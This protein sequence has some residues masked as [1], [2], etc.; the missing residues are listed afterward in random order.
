MLNP[1][2]GAGRLVCARVEDA[3]EARGFAVHRLE[4]GEDLAE[5]AARLAVEA[6]ALAVAGGDGSLAAGAAVAI[7]HGLP[8]LPVPTGSL[9]HFARDAGL[10]RSD[11]VG[12]LAAIDGEAHRVDVGLA[13]GRV[14][15]NTLSFGVYAE[16][17]RDADYRHHKLRVGHRVVV[18]DDVVRSFRVS[19]T[20]H[21]R[22]V[23]T[24]A[25]LVV[26]TNNAHV[27]RIAERERLDAGVLQVSA[28]L[29]DDPR[30]LRRAILRAAVLRRLDHEDGWLTRLT[31]A[32]EVS[33]DR[34]RLH[35]AL[36]GEPADFEP[37]IDIISRP[38]AL[39][40]LGVGAAHPRRGALTRVRR[41]L[42]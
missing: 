15:L 40:L 12:A 37:A 32:V 1:R 25:S 2:S 24:R 10:D 8:F 13:A 3:A 4:P 16:M 18:G 6:D 30:R 11:P 9:N 28:L 20:E 21:G 39:R 5:A 26:V 29:T 14:F 38:G 42:A 19:L 33:S 22:P 7:E 17:V 31:R 41:F 36:D 35:A 27:T 23:V 34:P